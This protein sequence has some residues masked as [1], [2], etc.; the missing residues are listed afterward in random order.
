MDFFPTILELAG[1][2]AMP[3]QHVDG[4]S[5]VP[6]LKGQAMPERDL[7]W[8]YPHYGNQGGEPSSIVRSG[9]WKLIFY[10]EDR[11]VELYNLADDIGEQTDLAGRQPQRVAELRTKLDAWLADTG[12]VMPKP[13]PRFDRQKFE[14]KLANARTKR[15]AGLE[16]QHANFLVPGWKPNADWWGSA[17]ARD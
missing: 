13:D 6:A 16:R 17:A 3:K 8:H 11:R 15:M 4:V 12:A 2:P 7:F 1:L 5:L 14:A 9:D 10:H